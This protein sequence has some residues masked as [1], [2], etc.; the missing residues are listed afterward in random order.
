MK[1]GGLLWEFAAVCMSLCCSYWQ[2]RQLEVQINGSSRLVN[3][4]EILKNKDIIKE[5]KK[6]F[7]AS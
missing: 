1:V 5:R 4:Q 2:E 7:M 6:I 3:L